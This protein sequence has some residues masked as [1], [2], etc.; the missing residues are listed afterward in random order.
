[1]NGVKVKFTFAPYN[2]SEKRIA[3]KGEPYS[4]ERTTDD[5]PGRYLC[6]VSSG[7]AIDGHGDRLLP[8]AIEDL[9]R[10]ATDHDIY[11]YAAHDRP[12]TDDIGLLKKSMLLDNGDWYTEYRLHDNNSEADR[13]WKMVN[14]ITPYTKARE[15][16]FSIEGLIPR[17]EYTTANGL[18]TGPKIVKRVILDQGVSVVTMPAYRP[19]HVVAIQKAFERDAMPIRREFP[20]IQKSELELLTERHKYDEQFENACEKIVFMDA[21]EEVLLKEIDKVFGE[22]KAACTPV[23]LGLARVERAEKTQG[24]AERAIKQ[25][26]MVND[27]TKIRN[28]LR[29]KTK[30]SK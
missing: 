4:F 6:G 3:K 20:I 14:G 8:E 27:L 23:L 19:S 11:L 21:P 5:A 7:T 26:A 18:P 28:E 10:Q 25:L 17:D 15:F 24:D 13:V 9:H 2:F 12:F 30:D 16:G 22:Y 29:N 1:M